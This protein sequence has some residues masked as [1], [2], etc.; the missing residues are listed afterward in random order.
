MSRLFPDG[1]K[2]VNYNYGQSFSEEGLLHQRY[3]DIVFGGIAKVT[4]PPN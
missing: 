4:L 2:N 3:K 1:R